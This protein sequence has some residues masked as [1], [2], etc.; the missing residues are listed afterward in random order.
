MIVGLGFDLVD[1][2]RARQMLVD[3][4]ERA[5]R[6]LCTSAEADY[7]LTQADA[8]MSFAARL[9]AKE[10]TFKALAGTEAARGI[11]WREI[12]VL[13]ATDG[14]PSIALHGAALARAGELGVTR[15]WLTLTHTATTAGAVVV[16]ESG[17]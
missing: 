2:A 3:R 17:A 1:V 14:R 8:A 7:C 12:E 5:L 9:A 15:T 13:R 16:L 4:G 6:R 10:A 11:G